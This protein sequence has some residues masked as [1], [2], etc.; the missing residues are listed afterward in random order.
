MRT[1]LIITFLIILVFFASC[2]KENEIIE[3]RERMFA[4]HINDIF[5]NAEEYLG[6]TV[7]LEG[8]FRT[9]LTNNGDQLF[10]VFRFAPDDCCASNGM[11][12]FEVRGQKSILTPGN[13]PENDSWVEVT[14]VLSEAVY[15]RRKYLYIELTS[16]IELD[17]RGAEFVER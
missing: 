17:I 9:G 7:R 2:A 10:Y 12:G 15:G 4:T 5:L 11:I 14:G 1:N 8:I 13:I 3:I 6:K 16:L